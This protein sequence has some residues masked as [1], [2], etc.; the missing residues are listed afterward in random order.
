[1]FGKEKHVLCFDAKEEADA[2]IEYFCKTLAET[3]SYETESKFDDIVRKERKGHKTPSKIDIDKLSINNTSNGKFEVRLNL[4][5]TY[6]Y[7]GT[8]P[9]VEDVD[10][11]IDILNPKLCQI[12]E[13]TKDLFKRVVDETRSKVCLKMHGSLLSEL[14][15]NELSGD[16]TFKQAHYDHALATGLDMIL[17]KLY[18]GDLVLVMRLRKG[19]NHNVALLH[20]TLKEFEMMLK[21][22]KANKWGRL[23]KLQNFNLF[24]KDETLK[25]FRENF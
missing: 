6:F 14:K 25:V 8:F 17:K 22:G 15:E 1:M 23:I 7:F 12:A 10:Y 3:K 16:V 11:F 21:H 4:L 20:A 5:G 19:K 2:F 18:L 13:V 9:A 24:E